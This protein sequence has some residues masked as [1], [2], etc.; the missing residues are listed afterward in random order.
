M[1]RLAHTFGSLKGRPRPGLVAYVTGGDPDA[2]RSLAVVR[3]IAEAGADVIEIGVPFS[4]PIA[5]GP[6]IQN[7]ST[8]ALAAVCS[9]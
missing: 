9:A 6:V 1:S 7:A 2:A 3:A 8:L 5:D 4:D